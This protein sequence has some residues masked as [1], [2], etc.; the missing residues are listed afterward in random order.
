[1][2]WIAVFDVPSSRPNMPFVES[3]ILRLPPFALLLL[4]LVHGK[5]C[6]SIGL[7]TE[8]SIFC[9]KRTDWKPGDESS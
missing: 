7:N 2:A 3:E 9:R 1:V 6:N 5:A 8:L 4:L